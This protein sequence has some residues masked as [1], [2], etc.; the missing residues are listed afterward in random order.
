M[1]HPTQIFLSNPQALRV[2]YRLDDARLILWWSPNAGR[3]TDCY[4]RNYSSRDAHLN[5]FESITLPGCELG[6]FEGC[7]YDPY[8]MVL[9][10]ERQTLHLALP[11]DVAAVV[12]WAEQSQGVDIKSARFAEA[13]S[14][15]E[16]SFAVTLAEPRHRF[17][18]AA[19]LGEGDGTLRH[20]HFHAP[21]QPYF[22]EAKLAGGQPLVLGVGLE[23][24]DI[25]A[26]IAALAADGPQ[27]LR[28]AT[29]AAL[30]PQ[31]RAG[32]IVSPRHP[33]L[34]SLRKSVIRGLHSMIDESGA[35]RA[36]LKAIYYLIWV[37]DSGFSFAYQAAAG[38]PH[39]LPELCRLLLDNP[40]SVQDAGLSNTRMFGQL[41][42]RELG[43][44]EEDG[45]YYVVWTLFTQWTQNRGLPEVSEADWRLIDEALVWVETVTW[46]GERGLFG[47]SFADETPVFGARDMGWDYAV[48]KPADDAYLKYEDRSVTRNYD[49]YFNNC[50]H[51]TYCMLAAMRSDPRYLEKAERVWPELE[52]LLN[53]RN[54][55]VPAYGELLF[56]D[57]VRKIAP[58]WGPVAG[59]SCCVWGLSMPNFL[60]LADSD[61]VHIAT[62]EAIA[63]KPDMHFVNGICSAIAAIDPWCF[64]E[65]A[66]LDFHKR[67]A[68]ETNTPGEYLPMGGA[69][70]EKFN[71]PQGN[72]YHDIRPQGFAMGAWLAA[73]SGLGLRRLPHGL[74][75]R[76]T[77]AFD[78]IESYAW[79]GK[80][81]TFHYGAGGRRLALEIDNKRIEGSLQVPEAELGERSTIRLVEVSEAR[82]LW[83]RSTVELKRVLWTGEHRRYEMVAHGLSQIA[84]SEAVDLDFEPTVGVVWTESLGIHTAHFTY[85]GDLVATLRS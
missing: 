3:S 79:R 83:L 32:H 38:W 65:A 46:D 43:K 7:E 82:P 28:R 53:V 33:E 49:V 19:A 11:V 70:P 57:G 45:L 25:Q 59:A 60:P 75:L 63:A 26:R 35:Y 73:W 10:F 24:E 85:F 51:G 12:L 29:D 47:G 30:A 9:R 13:E 74:A 37:R 31:E 39:K 61:A 67:L 84:F 18:M 27:A 41:V 58:H 4:D 72:L 44:L 17:E 20:C 5:V 40:T 71:A 64:D 8:H 23:G 22:V 69:M 55:G 54:Q 15:G 16:R 68:S 77:G 78:R 50:M 76:P 52:K 2:E 6:A 36:S 42:H 62:F 80:S 66:L 1:E 34:E 48:G 14:I 81:L 56:D 21:G